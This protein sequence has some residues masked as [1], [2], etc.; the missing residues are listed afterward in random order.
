M[1]KKRKSIGK[2]KKKIAVDLSEKGT[3]GKVP[4]VNTEPPGHFVP[5]R[6]AH[7]SDAHTSYDRHIVQCK[8]S[9]INSESTDHPC[10]HALCLACTK[11][12]M[13]NL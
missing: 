3:G 2:A 7:N 4:S 11:A 8:L 10:N 9:C 1:R 6:G 5:P 13:Q 12:M